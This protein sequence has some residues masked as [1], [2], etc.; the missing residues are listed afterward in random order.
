MV[1]SLVTTS[2]G[3]P[4]SSTATAGPYP[5][6]G[7]QRAMAPYTSRAWRKGPRK[8]TRATHPPAS[9]ALRKH[10]SSSPTSSPKSI[11]L[12]TLSTKLPKG[13]PLVVGEKSWSVFTT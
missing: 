8:A 13:L 9:R 12:T 1:T 10:C 2:L 3:V 4:R 11:R 6:S 7:K 5:A